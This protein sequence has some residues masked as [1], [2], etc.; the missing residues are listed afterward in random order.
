MLGEKDFPSRA[1]LEL[2][3][4][5]QHLQHVHLVRQT[6]S[7]NF[8]QMLAV[9]CPHIE[10]LAMSHCKGNQDRP[11]HLDWCHMTSF[12]KLRNL[13]MDFHSLGRFYSRYLHLA[14]VTKVLFHDILERLETISLKGNVG[15]IL[16]GD[17]YDRMLA[18]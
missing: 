8:L 9:H 18:Q 10:T 13:H 4:K 3:S 15:Q 5:M 2:L 12:H 11:I 7:S 6:V 16:N 17:H 1:K 14:S